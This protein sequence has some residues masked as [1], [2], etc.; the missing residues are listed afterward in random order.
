MPSSTSDPERIPAIGIQELVVTYGGKPAVAGLTLTVPRGTIFGFLGPNGSG[1]TTTIKTLLGMR[2]QDSG[3]ARV[4]GLDT[5][6][7]GQAI[8]ERVAFVSEV[9]SLYE[10]MDVPQLCAFCRSTSGTWNQPV[11]DH[12]LDLFALPRKGPIGHFSKGMKSQLALCLAVGGDPELFILDEPTSGLD[13]LARREVLNRL[14]GEIAANGKTVFFSS[15]LLAEVEAV[16]DWVGIIRAG[17]LVVSDTL[18]HLKQSQK[19]LRLTYPRAPAES[20]LAA[21]RA[22]PDVISALQEGRS[23]RVLTRGDVEL[24]ARHVRALADA[25]RTVDTVELNLDDIFS[26][27]MT[28]R[29][30]GL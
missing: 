16:A 7:E 6:T 13:P 20:D 17:K 23:V 30:D 22:L 18:D 28:E 29:G 11:V 19:V 3:S 14:V 2:R 5:L 12:Y 10:F 8:R 25:P 15:H 9:N 4:L 26:S 27:F 21:L 24:T 1:K